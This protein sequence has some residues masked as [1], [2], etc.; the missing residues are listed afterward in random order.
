LKKKASPLS[1]Q[2]NHWY[3]RWY[4][5]YDFLYYIKNFSIISSDDRVFFADKSVRQVSNN[6]CLFF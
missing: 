3:R 4:Q 1:S 6:F 5:W 2:K